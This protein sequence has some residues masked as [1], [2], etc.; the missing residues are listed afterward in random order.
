MK[1]Y[2]ALPFDHVMIKTNGDFN[3]C[4]QH[5]ISSCESKN[6]NH[7][8]YD[9]WLS[10]EYVQTVRQSFEQD[11]RHPGCVKCWQREDAGFSSLRTRSQKEYSLLP[12]DKDRPIKNLQIDLGNLCNLRC[13][14][15][16]ERASSAI[17]AENVKLGINK[18]QQA[19]VS[20]QQTSYDN[21]QKILD[22]RPYV[23]NIRG[24]E[25]FYNKDLLNLVENIPESHAQNMMLHITTN[26]TTWN[27]RWQ[28]GLKKFRLVRIMFSVDAIGSLYQ[29]IR[30]P[31]SWSAVEQNIQ[32]IR[33]LS[34]VRCLVHAVGQNLNIGNIAPLIQWCE[35]NA[36]YLEIESLISPDYLQITN[37]PPEHKL[38]VIEHLDRLIA[39][40]LPLH[41]EEF[42]ISAR[43]SLEHSKFDPLLWQ[44]FITNIG[45][46][47]RIRNN[48]FTEFIGATQC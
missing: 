1:N 19:D 5:V 25:P 48:S 38:L 4:C 21:L 14:M 26:A 44:K 11:L 22:Q 6:I 27:D 45:R 33:S 20:W 40:S 46:R 31:A 30:Y 3:I 29:Y 32:S 13:L 42:V 34:N 35:N 15:C 41:L 43:D 7:D 12:S 23:V 28:Q 36:L 8:S 39:R 2:C 18:I 47:D 10:S 9:S 16:N 24:G 37:L 17:L